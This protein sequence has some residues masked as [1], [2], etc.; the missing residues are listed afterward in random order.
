M[1]IGPTGPYAYGK[2]G[3]PVASQFGPEAIGARFKARAGPAHSHLDQPLASSLFLSHHSSSS[4][5]HQHSEQGH[6]GRD[7][8]LKQD[9]IGF[10][11]LSIYLLGSVSCVRT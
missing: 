5:Q 4:L 9:A 11:L 6:Y 10:V 3:R 2:L 8:A 1:P 7:G